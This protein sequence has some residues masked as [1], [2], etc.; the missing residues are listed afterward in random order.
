MVMMYFWFLNQKSAERLLHPDG[1]RRAG[2]ERCA[3][4]CRARDRRAPGSTPPSNGR[5]V[6]IWNSCCHDA[7]SALLLR[8]ASC[9]CG[10]RA[11]LISGVPSPRT[12]RR[13]L[14]ALLM[15]ALGTRCKNHLRSGMEQHRAAA[16]SSQEWFTTA[17][18]QTR[19]TRGRCCT[20]C[21]LYQLVCAFAR[22]CPPFF[23]LADAPDPM[24]LRGLGW[25]AL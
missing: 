25:L 16:A 18:K 15:F 5:D 8:V 12:P 13:F 11:S 4:H 20:G 3:V 17:S 23:E 2:W 21:G 19:H 9:Q 6:A 24:S 14:P 10:M 22:S 1:A 7:S